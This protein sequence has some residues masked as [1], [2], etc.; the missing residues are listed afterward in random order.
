MSN[1]DKR[2]LIFTLQGS[3]YA[4]D[5]AQVAEVGDPPQMWPIPLAPACYSGAVN[6]HG[7]IVAVMNLSVFLD[8]DGNNQPSKIIVLHKRLASLAFLVDAVIKIIAEV[9]VSFCKPPEKRF[10]IATLNLPDGEAVQLDIEALVLS[11]GD[12]MRGGRL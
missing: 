12:G 11:A 2:F 6:F 7:D 5:L 10:A 1:S 3:Q 8:I 9:E 4:L